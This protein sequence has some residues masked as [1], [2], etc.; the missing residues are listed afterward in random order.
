MRHEGRVSPTIESGA[1]APTI[2]GRYTREELLLMSRWVV[3][4]IETMDTETLRRFANGC[5]GLACI[6][7]NLEAAEKRLKILR[8]KNK[9]TPHQPDVMFALHILNKPAISSEAQA[10][11]T[12]LRG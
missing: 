9:T 3:P 10:R 6:P 11:A 12:F 8:D 1:R 5:A 4:D 2:P 7:G